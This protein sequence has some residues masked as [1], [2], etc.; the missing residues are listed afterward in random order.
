MATHFPRQRLVSG[1]HKRAYLTTLCCLLML[2][3]WL[4]LAFAGDS[5][6]G[7]VIEV[8][9]AD[10]V[11]LDYGE[12]KY[13]VRIAG[14]L[15]PREAQ[16]VKNS[17]EFVSKLVL[18]QNVR[19]RFDGF[20]KKGEMVGQLQTDDPQRGIQDVGL[21]LVRS[22]LVRRQPN[23]DYKYQKLS[24]AEKEAQRA[25]RGTWATAPAQ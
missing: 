22:G 6:Y 2:L 11:V 17:K 9:S 21:E 1:S 25:K 18:R 23:Y 16:L 8:K 12:G 4:P 14:V 13:Q 19:L 24:M 10:L 5:I 15:M 7:K 3:G 20:N